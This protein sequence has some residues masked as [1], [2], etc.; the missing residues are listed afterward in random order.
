MIVLATTSLLTGLPCELDPNATCDAIKDG[1]V[2]GL[3]FKSA[4]RLADQHPPGSAPEVKGDPPTSYYVYVPQPVCGNVTPGNTEGNSCEHADKRCDTAAG[5]GPF[6]VIHK[7]EMLTK[8]DE[9]QSGWQQVGLTCFPEA[10]PGRSGQVADERIAKAFKVTKFAVPVPTWDPPRDNPL[11]NKPVY[12]MAE[13]AEAGYESGEERHIQPAEMLGHELQIMP[14]LKYVTYDFG[15][16]TTEGPTADTGGEYP[17]GK[18]THT[19]EKTNPVKPGITATYTGSYSLDGGPWRPLGI[20]VDVASQPK[21]LTP[22]T[23]TTELVLP[24]E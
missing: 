8:D 24:P 17:D 11:V 23:W 9:P 10:V 4:A 16:G 7:R 6:M 22:T 18:I 1:A 13:F 14:E 19:Y 15:D 5:D 2:V 3:S 12:F 21:T 20:N